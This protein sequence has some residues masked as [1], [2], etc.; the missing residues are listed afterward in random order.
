MFGGRVRADRALDVAASAAINWRRF[1]ELISSSLRVNFTPPEGQ[2]ATGTPSESGRSYGCAPRRAE[3]QLFVTQ[4]RC[5]TCIPDIAQGRN[6]KF[7]PGRKQGRTSAGASERV[8][9]GELEL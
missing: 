7:R 6:R 1:G 9:Q 3:T 2:D 5:G 4:R 8:S